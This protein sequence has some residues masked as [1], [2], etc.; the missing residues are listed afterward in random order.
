M[1]PIFG[2]MIRTEIH[3]TITS[4]SGVGRCNDDDDDDDD[5][6]DHDDDDDGPVLLIL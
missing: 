2:A 6:D 5:D 3:A 4:C 1:N